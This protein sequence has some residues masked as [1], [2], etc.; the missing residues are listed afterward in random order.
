MHHGIEVQEGQRYE[1]VFTFLGRKNRF[2]VCSR[3]TVWHVQSVS[4][5]F[6]AAPHAW[7]VN[8]DDP[9]DIRLVSCETLA[10][11]RY[12]KLVGEPEKRQAI[13]AE[14]A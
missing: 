5:R 6:L 12:F 11:D 3:P 9:R 8:Q 1:K 14:A 13:Q 4:T 10:D 7:L 2:R